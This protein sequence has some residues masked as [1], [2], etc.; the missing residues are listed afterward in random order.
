MRFVST[1]GQS[2][3]VEFCEAVSQGLA[4]DGGL[5]LPETFPDLSECVG[6]WS[7]L[8]YPQLCLEFFRLFATDLEPE[9]L[10]K[11]IDASY[12]GFGHPETAPLVELS[13]HCKVLELFHGPTLA[14]KDFALQLLG[15]LY[16]IQI[17]RT[18]RNLTIL[19]ATSGDTGPPRSPVFSGSV[20]S[21][22]SSSIPTGRFPLCRN[23]K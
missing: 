4:P 14:F 22:C 21:R 16:E 12:A 20:G 1:R 3:S 17:A 8:S 23:A 15:N 5:Y 11:V 9:V 10:K 2:G 19:G 7:D 6:L 18:G 13:D